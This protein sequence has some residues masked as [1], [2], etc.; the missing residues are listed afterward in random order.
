MMPLHIANAIIQSKGGNPIVLHM[1]DTEKAEPLLSTLNSHLSQ[2]L[3]LHPSFIA[4][5]PDGINIQCLDPNDPSES[6]D[7]EGRRDPSNL[8]TLSNRAIDHVGTFK[9]ELEDA[10]G[11]NDVAN[12]MTELEEPRL[13]GNDATSDEGGTGYQYV[14]DEV[15]FDLSV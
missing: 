7:R 2:S 15:P 8:D 13:A 11:V 9:G 1:V 10:L 5:E 14:R 6:S 4:E 3:L 12:P